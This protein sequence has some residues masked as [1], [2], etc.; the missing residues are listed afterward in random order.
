MG[1]IFRYMH[2][3]SLY[4]AQNSNIS[5][6]E[7][8]KDDLVRHL[9]IKR[10]NIRVYERCK[11]FVKSYSA[12]W[13]NWGLLEKKEGVVRRTTAFENA[14]ISRRVLWIA[15]IRDLTPENLGNASSPA[16]TETTQKSKRVS[17]AFLSTSMRQYSSNG[18][19]A[20]RTI[21]SATSY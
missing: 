3:Y 9:N 4:T 5:A 21:S 7:R 17:G 20:Q 15:H 1:Y 11:Q 2:D 19:K 16:E 14:L 6:I 8:F 12:T 18:S 13:L 10:D